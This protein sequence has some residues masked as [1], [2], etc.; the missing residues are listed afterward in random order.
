MLRKGGGSGRE[1]REGDGELPPEHTRAS[2][3]R[4][5]GQKQACKG[6]KATE[7]RVKLKMTQRGGPVAEETPGAFNYTLFHLPTDF[8]HSQLILALHAPGSP[9]KHTEFLIL[10]YLSGNERHWGIHWEPLS[11]EGINITS[12]FLVN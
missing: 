2:L 3:V 10:S 6:Q 9:G 8:A 11:A 7:K 1:M 4:P 12:C 5:Q